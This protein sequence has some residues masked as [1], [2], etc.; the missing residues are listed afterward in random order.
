VLGYSRDE[1]LTLREKE[2]FEA[3]VNANRLLANSE[4]LSVSDFP[5]RAERSKAKKNSSSATVG[6]LYE[7]PFFLEST[8]RAIIERDAKKAS[9]R[10]C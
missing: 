8:I 7:R 1:V 3:K 2:R 5:I 9:A 10:V 4:C 6:A